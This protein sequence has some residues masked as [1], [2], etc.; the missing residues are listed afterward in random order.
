MAEIITSLNERISNNTEAREQKL[1]NI[2]EY[3]V[4]ELTDRLDTL[5]MLGPD[6]KHLVLRAWSANYIVSPSGAPV[7]SLT[8]ATAVSGR[9]L[10]KQKITVPLPGA[11]SVTHTW[12]RFFDW[13]PIAVTTAPRIRAFLSLF[14]F[15]LNILSPNRWAKCLDRAR[16]HISLPCLR[17]KH[18]GIEFGGSDAALGTL[19]ICELTEGIN[20]A[21]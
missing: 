15:S 1:T 9:N 14:N 11:V 12:W 13:R 7:V 6:A 4:T 21:V 17:K 19:T 2:R 8:F 5:G 20:I 16:K 10:K 3:L 18:V